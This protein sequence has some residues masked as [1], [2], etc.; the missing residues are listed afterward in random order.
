MQEYKSKVVGSRAKREKFFKDL[1][2]TL[3]N[4]SALDLS[5]KKKHFCRVFITGNE[6]KKL[7]K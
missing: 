4:S 3:L 6:N 1:Y 7:L 5:L 2:F